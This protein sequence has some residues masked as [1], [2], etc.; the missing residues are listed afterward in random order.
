MPGASAGRRRRARELRIAV[1]IGL[2]CS[3]IM[4]G[5]IYLLYLTG[6]M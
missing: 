4:G 5:L 6:N 3:I 2:A 1:Y